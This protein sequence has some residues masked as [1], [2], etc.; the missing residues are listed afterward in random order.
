[1]GIFLLRAP[2][3]ATNKLWFMLIRSGELLIGYIAVTLIPL[4]SSVFD[5]YW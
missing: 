2:I 4:I 5:N 3:G 1:M